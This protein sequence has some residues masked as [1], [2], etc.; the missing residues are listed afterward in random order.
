MRIYDIRDSEQ[1]IFAFEVENF[2]LSRRLVC[3]IVGQIPACILIREPK[4]SFWPFSNDDD[5]CEFELEGVR[6]I[7]NEPWGD[8]GRYWIGPKAEES[9]PAKWS[10][11]IECVREAFMQARPFFGYLRK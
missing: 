7:A 11:Q 8:N 6:F 10:P 9:R 1:R 5:F 3:R 4:E 2:H